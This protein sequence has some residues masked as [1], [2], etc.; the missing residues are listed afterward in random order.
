MYL[1]GQPGHKDS[2]F[3]F[4]GEK[5][6]FAWTYFIQVTRFRVPS[7]ASD[8]LTPPAPSAERPRP[9]PAWRP[10]RGPGPVLGLGRALCP[11]PPWQSSRRGRALAT[12]HLRVPLAAVRERRALPGRGVPQPPPPKNIPLFRAVGR[13]RRGRGSPRRKASLQRCPA[14]RGWPVCS[15]VSP[16][17]PPCV[18]VPPGG[19]GGGRSAGRGAP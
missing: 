19:G 1:T 8:A 2:V 9:A 18:R 4:S 6:S 11:L 15:S 10:A 16:P 5:R 3:V 12:R 17:P 14:G 13:A 7:L